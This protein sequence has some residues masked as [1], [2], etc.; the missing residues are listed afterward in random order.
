[1]AAR[2]TSLPIS[3]AVGLRRT[4]AAPHLSSQQLRASRG[5]AKQ[6]AAL[7][8]SI[9]GMNARYLGL[10]ALSALSAAALLSRP[11]ASAVVFPDCALGADAQTPSLGFS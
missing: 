11:K 8:K 9:S 2:I 5:R 10:T 1:M 6:F 7:L 4:A 3:N